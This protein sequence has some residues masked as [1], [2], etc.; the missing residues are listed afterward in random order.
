MKLYGNG[1]IVTICEE[2]DQY[3]G[4]KEIRTVLQSTMRGGDL[5][6]DFRTFNPPISKNN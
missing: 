2:L 6:W 3:A 1:I 5:F 4:E